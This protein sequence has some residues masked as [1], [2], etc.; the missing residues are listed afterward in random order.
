MKGELYI[1]GGE[2]GAISPEE[3]PETIHMDITADDLTDLK[4]GNE[5]VITI[6]G[7]V[8]ELG[9][10]KYSGPNLSLEVAS[11]SIRKTGNAQME[12]IRK[13]L[14][15]DDEEESGGY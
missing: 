7:C 3:P 1:T 8:K 6:K 5:V 15:D 10:N 14:G 11:K 2:S 4:I 13:I 9:A 12:G